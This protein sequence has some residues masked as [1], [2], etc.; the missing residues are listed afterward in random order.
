MMS[1]SDEE[2]EGHGV[3]DNTLVLF[4]TDNGPRSSPGPMADDAIRA[5]QDRH[6]GG[7]CCNPRYSARCR[8]AGAERDLSGMDGS[9]HL[10]A[11]GNPDITDQLLK[12]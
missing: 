12:A 4:T 8:R 1:A 3:D 10:T 9:R 5:K 11:A 7:V 2:A 6:E